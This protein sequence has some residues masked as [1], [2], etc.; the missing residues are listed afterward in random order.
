MAMFASLG[1]AQ[2]VASLPAGAG[3]TDAKTA[4][5][6]AGSHQTPKPLEGCFG[7]LAD[8]LE[9]QQWVE[10][11]GELPK[12]EYRAP[13][14]AGEG[15]TYTYSGFNSEGGGTGDNGNPRGG[16]VNF[17]LNPFACDS[18]CSD[19][20]LSPYAFVK[21]GKLY[22][23]QPIQNR[24]DGSCPKQQRT[25]FDANTFELLEQETFDTA[26]GGKTSYCG[27]YFAYDELSDVIW[28][29]STETETIYTPLFDNIQTTYLNIY[30]PLTGRL[31]RVGALGEWRYTGDDMDNYALKS[32]C[33]IEGNLYSQLKRGDKMILVRINPWTLETTQ[34]GK[35][36]MTTK[37]CVDLNPM[38][39]KDESTL[40]VNHYDLYT[41]TTYYEVSTFSRD[42]G[43][44]VKT[45]EVEKLPT[46]YSMF[47]QRPETLT[48][49]ASN[50]E[51]VEDLAVSVDDAFTEIS[52]SFTVPSRMADGSE[53][54]YPYW[55]TDLQKTVRPTVFIDGNATTAVIDCGT[56]VAYGKKATAKVVLADNSWL[57]IK[58]GLHT[59]ALKLFSNYNGAHF[60]NSSV[61]AVLGSDAPSAVSSPKLAIADG[62]ATISWTAPTVA[63]HED[64][65]G[66]FAPSALTYTVIRDDG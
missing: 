32:L 56:N 34:V 2:T 7:S 28:A 5:K 39:M 45:T 48:Q 35:T 66:T 53:L 33:C 6:M 36:D 20:G 11:H 44:T 17:N 55:V 25:I 61:T 21:D 1:M 43:A 4:Q 13:R 37:G 3:G 15:V 42:Q 19:G 12:H 58:P 22:A 27:M 49:T 24:E 51:P 23:I 26:H 14:K 57:D 59:V 31:N 41:G 10:A 46:G 54:E 9:R 18:V 38:I 8:A 16:M 40:L 65:G 50:M 64:F 63:E 52:V 30:D 47:Y 62:V 60:H 29:L